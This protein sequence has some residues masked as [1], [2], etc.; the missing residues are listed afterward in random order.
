MYHEN[1]NYEQNNFFKD[2]QRNGVQ[3]VI[4]RLSCLAKHYPDGHIVPDMLDN[5][6]LFYPDKNTDEHIQVLLD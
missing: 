1:E 3:D 4:R 5:C 2:T 6:L